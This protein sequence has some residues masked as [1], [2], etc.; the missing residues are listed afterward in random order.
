MLK[1]I[2]NTI[3][4]CKYLKT[5]E[6]VPV[7]LNNDFVKGNGFM[8]SAVFKGSSN[9]II[10]VDNEFLTLSKRT[11]EYILQHEIGHIINGHL[12]LTEI[13]YDARMNDLLNNKVLNIEL[14]ADMYACKVI[15]LDNFIGS[16]NELINRSDLYD[17][18]IK[19]YCLRAKK[20]LENL[21]SPN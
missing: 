8:F 15:G 1:E 18:T 20:V 17:F 10:A 6:G 2:F 19:E 14:E 4:K 11:Q 5:C 3:F 13:S 9:Y 21:G 16:I 7:Y 12:N